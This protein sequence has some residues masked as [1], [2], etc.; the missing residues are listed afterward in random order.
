MAINS[1]FLTIFFL[2]GGKIV[3]AGD[4][5]DAPKYEYF[6]GIVESVLEERNDEAKSQFYQKLKIKALN[7][8]LI[9]REIVVEN[10]GFTLA[11]YN[12]YK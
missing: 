9:G 12:K 6:R 1:L 11:Q 8:S 2:L 5:V 4:N 7:G 3:W 10:G